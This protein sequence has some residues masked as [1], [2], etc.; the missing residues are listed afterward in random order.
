MNP[1]TLC[2]IVVSGNQ[3]LAA[4]RDII[5]VQIIEVDPRRIAALCR[6][7]DQ[8]LRRSRP[9]ID[10][11]RDRIIQEARRMRRAG[12]TLAVIARKFGISTA[13]ASKWCRDIASGPLPR[14]V[15]DV[16]QRGRGVKAA[17][18][19]GDA[20]R[21]A[22]SGSQ[23]TGAAGALVGPGPGHDGPPP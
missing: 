7:I 8:A 2:S 19:I 21:P 10:P 9:V 5:V 6:R 12:A 20:P 23:Q 3:N 15:E 14:G 17:S 18:P 13:L 11:A 4:G 16:L 1:N 22:R